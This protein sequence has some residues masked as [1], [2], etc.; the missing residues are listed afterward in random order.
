MFDKRTILKNITW[1][2]ASSIATN[3]TSAILGILVARYLGSY[4]YG[5]YASAVVVSMFFG[6]FLDFGYSE[7]M[8]REGSRDQ[9]KIK[10]YLGSALLSYCLAFGAAYT[11]MVFY[12][13]VVG[14]PRTVI[15]LIVVYGVGAFFTRGLRTW[16][17]LFRV[18]QRLDIQAKLEMSASFLRA[19][20]LGA[21]LWLR[22]GLMELVSIHAFVSILSFL[23]YMKIG[24]SMYKPVF[25]FTRTMKQIGPASPFGL[26]AMLYFLYSQINV[27]VLSLMVQP[28]GIGAFAAAL[29]IIT[30][31][32]ELPII[33]FNSN[34]LP[35]MFITYKTDRQYLRRLYALSAKYMLGLGVLFSF[36]IGFY[37]KPIVH[38]IY[39][40]SY[41]QAFLPLQIL[42]LCVF[43]RYLSCGA[44]ATLTAVDRMKDKVF[45]QLSVALVAIVLNVV[46][47]PKYSLLGA[48][49]ATV[50]SETTLLGLLVYRTGKNFSWLSVVGDLQVH[51]LALTG[52]ILLPLALLAQGRVADYVAGC[53]LFVLGL[54]ILCGSKFFDLRVL[55]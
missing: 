17:G 10:P 38:S 4:N 55:R 51:K 22:L 27:F 37:A 39:G 35:L 45:V 26:S 50:I 2:Q 19:A 13:W 48:A 23:V 15:L 24:R 3:G 53:L 6:L 43:L 25:S 8:V 18:Q 36:F 7:L 31:A 40:R 11:T 34:L 44:E 32:N 9:A 28:D 14:Y 16:E 54:L 41:E 46:L 52:S 49:L 30:L 21:Y 5:L 20:M 47:I 12:A 29:R 33:V 1:L 42:S